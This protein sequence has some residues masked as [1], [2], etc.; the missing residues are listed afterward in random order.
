[1]IGEPKDSASYFEDYGYHYH[2]QLSLLPSNDHLQDGAELL[3]SNYFVPPREPYCKLHFF[4]KVI[5][6]H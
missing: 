2:F 4:V 6:Y 5:S 1:M 3:S